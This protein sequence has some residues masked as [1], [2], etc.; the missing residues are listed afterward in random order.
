MTETIEF[1]N[2]INLP[3]KLKLPKFNRRN[4]KLLDNS[5]FIYCELVSFKLRNLKPAVTKLYRTSSNLNP[6]LLTALKELINLV[7]NKS[8]VICKADKDG[9]IIVLDFDDYIN[10]MNRELKTFTL[11]SDINNNNVYK[12]FDEIRKQN[13]SL[14]IELQKQGVID[15]FLLKHIIGVKCYGNK[16]IYIF[17]VL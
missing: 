10:I 13:D 14:I 11:Y 3:P 8:I 17:L 5:M 12:Y 1:S 16:Y 2:Q 4:S 9:K 6:D 7:K 15:D